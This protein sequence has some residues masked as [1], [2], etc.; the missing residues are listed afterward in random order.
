VHSAAS[1]VGLAFGLALSEAT[2]DG[3]AAGLI[4]GALNAGS[5]DVT[6]VGLDVDEV[7]QAAAVRAK[8]ESA[9]RPER[10]ARNRGGRVFMSKL[11]RV[12]L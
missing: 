3:L 9:T 7:P 8:T 1:P 2:N 4:G 6:N 5:D 10:A 12:L 11:L